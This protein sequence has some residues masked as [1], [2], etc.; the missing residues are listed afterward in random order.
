M[1]Q[2]LVVVVLLAGLV[3][4]LWVMTLAIWEGQQSTTRAQEAERSR[5]SDDVQPRDTAMKR[6][7]KQQSF[8][9]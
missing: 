8:A 5:H 3:G 1:T 9:A 6:A 2:E 4:F 7:L